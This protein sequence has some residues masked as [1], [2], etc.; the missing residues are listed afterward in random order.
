MST[1]CPAVIAMSPASHCVGGS[2]IS[3]QSKAS[4]TVR[5][6]YRWRLS[7]LRR[8]LAHC[9]DSLTH[10]WLP[11]SMADLYLSIV[12]VATV[13]LFR[14]TSNLSNIRT[15][16]SISIA[17][18]CGNIYLTIAHSDWTLHYTSLQLVNLYG[19]EGNSKGGMWA[20]LQCACKHVHMCTSP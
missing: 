17:Q 1:V 15:N 18:L 5:R 14:A 19:C 11:H 10:L 3:R 4:S 2:G 12:S 8:T 20:P 7:R 9:T 6:H 13:C 16:G